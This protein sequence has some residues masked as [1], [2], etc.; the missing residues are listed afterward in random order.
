MT[1]PKTFP[2]ATVREVDGELVL[3]DPVAVEVIGT[4]ERI[5]LYRADE[6]AV[7]R[8]EARA[9][10]K[11]KE[12]GEEFVVVVIEVD[13]TLWRPLA[14][15]LMPD[16]DWDQFRKLGQI[17]I[18]RGVVPRKFIVDLLVETMKVPRFPDGV[19]TAVFGANGVTVC[20]L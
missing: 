6:V 17:P 20:E 15:H 8:L 11:T 10:E 14:D 1:N 3:D 5:N 7:K 18:A 12:T 4:V 16:H 19:F 2:Q 13:D 9:A